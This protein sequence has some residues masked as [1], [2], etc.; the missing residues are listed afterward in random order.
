MLSMNYV[1]PY[2]VSGYMKICYSVTGLGQVFMIC[3]ITI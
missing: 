2:G 1:T 3:Y